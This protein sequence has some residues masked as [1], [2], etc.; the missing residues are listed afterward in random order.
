MA[1]SQREASGNRGSGPG[2]QSFVPGP[3]RS[4]GRTPAAAT[5]G[6]E[7]DDGLTDPRFTYQ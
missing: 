2:A 6:I 5:S 7:D 1:S 3:G 4:V